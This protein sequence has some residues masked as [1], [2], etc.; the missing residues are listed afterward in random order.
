[1]HIINHRDNAS[2]CVQE[3]PDEGSG[4]VNK[5]SVG[6]IGMQT[7]FTVLTLFTILFPFCSEYV[8]LGRK[9]FR[10]IQEKRR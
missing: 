2:D 4:D 3:N 10:P 1:M 7:S 9:L 5:G 8:S 6:V